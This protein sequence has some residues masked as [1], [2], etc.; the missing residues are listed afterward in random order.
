MCVD[1]TRGESGLLTE[2]HKTVIAKWSMRADGRGV[3]HGVGGGGA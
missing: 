1:V 3:N 2:L